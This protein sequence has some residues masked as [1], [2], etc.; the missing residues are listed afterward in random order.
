MA[1][2]APNL[3]SLGSLGWEVPTGTATVAISVSI[4]LT[5]GGH[6]KALLVVL[7]LYQ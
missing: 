7:L 1:L 4:Q 3:H 2:V 6:G 5:A